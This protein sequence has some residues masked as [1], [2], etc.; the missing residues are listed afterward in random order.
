MKEASASSDKKTRLIKRYPNRKLYD[1]AASTYV[2]LEDIAG[3]IRQGEEDVRVVDN[4]THED[5]T[6]ITLTQI[7]FEEEKKKKS[8]LPL[9]TLKE[10]IQAKGEKIVDLVS[11][12]VSSFTHVREEAEKKIKTA[13]ESVSNLPSV[14][15]EITALQKKIDLLE[16]RLKKYEK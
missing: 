10:I 12:G 6:S 13:L 2:T 14:Q 9:A 7:I 11:S 3:M 16:A 1:T 8:L 5:L 4:R 15:K